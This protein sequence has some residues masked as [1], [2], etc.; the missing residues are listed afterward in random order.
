MSRIRFVPIMLIFM[1]SLSVMFGGWELYRKFGLVGPLEQQLAADKNVTHVES[2]VNGQD[3]EIK[4]TL[5]KV[6]DLQTT[7]EDLE[8]IIG[9]QMGS[10]VKIDLV[11]DHTQ[12]LKNVYRSI[13]PI[14]YSGIAK[15]DFEAMIQEAE[16]AAKA[17]G[18][19]GEITMDDHNIYV[20]VQKNGHTLYEVLPYKLLK[21][22]GLMEVQTSL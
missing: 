2:V 17:S 14:L 13:Q 6:T 19:Q 9:A 10:Q 4:V 5:K 21:L 15:G 16:K 1:V 18:S 3:R 20:N 7:Y 8:T 22:D 11:D 12:D